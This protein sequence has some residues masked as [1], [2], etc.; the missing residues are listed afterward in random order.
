MKLKQVNLSDDEM[1]VAGKGKTISKKNLFKLFVDFD[2]PECILEDFNNNQIDNDLIDGWRI[3]YYFSI[4]DFTLTF[5]IEEYD[6]VY[7]TLKSY[8]R[9]IRINKVLN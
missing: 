8:V 4:G 7:Q 1:I 2:C 3:L 5:T 6:F 9:D